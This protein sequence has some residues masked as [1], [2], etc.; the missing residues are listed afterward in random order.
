MHANL[1]CGDK[2]MGGLKRPAFHAMIRLCIQ[3]SS[4]YTGANHWT[5][6]QTAPQGGT[7]HVKQQMKPIK[8]MGSEL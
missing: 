7:N 1:E 4:L 2:Y 5:R 6:P 3:V 8:L